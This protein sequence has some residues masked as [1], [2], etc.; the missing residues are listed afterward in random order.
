M[1]RIQWKRKKSLKKGEEKKNIFL[2]LYFYCKFTIIKPYFNS[3][4]I[5][6]FRHFLL[7]VCHFFFI[8]LVPF[9]F[10]LSY[11]YHFFIIAFIKMSF[12]P[13][14]IFVEITQ[15]P[16]QQKCYLITHFPFIQ[17]IK[18]LLNNTFLK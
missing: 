16:K 5:L 10:F 18:M 17:T 7:F 1:F 15:F 9:F 6:Q 12:F 3:F 4:K 11:F 2:E 13:F 8:L 14:H